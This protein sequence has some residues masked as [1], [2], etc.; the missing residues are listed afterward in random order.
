MPSRNGSGFLVALAVCVLVL[1]AIPSGAAAS[2]DDGGPVNVRSCGVTIDEPGTY[3]LTQ[4][5]IDNR[6][7]GLSENCISIESSDVVFDGQGF[8]IDGNGV[9]DTAGISV[10][11]GSHVSN[12]T[13][14][15][16][17]VS[18]WGRGLY[19]N[20][21]SG[22]T[23]ENVEASL[24]G[25]GIT[26]ANASDVEVRGPAVRDNLIGVFLD[27]TSNSAVRDVTATGNQV[28]IKVDETSENNTLP[29]SGV[30]RDRRVG[31]FEQLLPSGLHGVDFPDSVLIATDSVGRPA[32]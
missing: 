21:V 31:I 3:V 11:N 27:G 1:G 25:F 23:V 4:D 5:I 24:N 26:I 7:V 13:V 30:Q 15:D 29:E 17:T 18:D 28:T 14:K 20:N 19:Y 10:A 2:Q 9:S 12:V 8:T 6:A 32:P 22:G 16:V